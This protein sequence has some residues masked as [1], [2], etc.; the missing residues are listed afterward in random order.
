MRGPRPTPHASGSRWCR[1][2][3]PFSVLAVV[4]V[5]IVALC[6]MAC[7]ESPPS[8]DREEEDGPADRFGLIQVSYEEHR[9]PG[10]AKPQLH[11]SGLFVRH[12]GLSRSSVLSLLDQSPTPVPGMD[13]VEV[14]QCVL[15]SR[16]LGRPNEDADGYV[17]LMDAG[18]VGMELG[19]RVTRLQHRY[20]PD[21]QGYV[22]GLSYE[23]ALPARSAPVA[24]GFLT[25]TGSGSPRVG[26]F[27]VRLAVPPVPRL[28][29]LNDEPITS[30]WADVDFDQDLELGWVAAETAPEQAGPVY[31]ELAV[32]HFDRTSSLVCVA[33]DSGRFTLPR[34]TLQRLEQVV[35]PDATVRLV[36]RRAAGS[37]FAAAGL[38]TGRALFVSRDS[39]LLR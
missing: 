34:E 3:L 33:P 20:W 17:E 4:F 12:V 31:V 7:F 13:T 1:F 26:N 2:T 10:G 21:R 25:L 36:M 27:M 24:T 8:Q 35:T 5:G 29:T 39:V 32:M 30:I 18:V 23:G 19:P 6:V 11:A 14:G 16:D 28:L 9:V 22:E 37:A 15:Q 38:Q